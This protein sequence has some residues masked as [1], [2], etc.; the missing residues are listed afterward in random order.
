MS[1]KWLDRLVYLIFFLATAYLFS[2]M[3]T[4][5]WHSL[6]EMGG[7]G[8]KNTYT[9]IYQLIYGRGFHFDGMNYPFG[10]QI[11]Y[12][13]GQS[14]LSVP[15]SYLKHRLTLEQGLA[16]MWYAIQL[17]YF[18]AM[19]FIYKILKLY[20]VEVLVAAVFSILIIYLSPQIHRLHSHFALSYSC[21]I[22]ILIYYTILYD[23]YGKLKYLLLLFPVCILFEFIHPYFAATLLVWTAFYSIMYWLVK[24]NKPLFKA[25]HL[26]N[27]WLG[28]VF[29]FGIFK[30]V[31][32][33]TDKVTD[34][35]ITPHG[36][37]EYCVEFKNIFTSGYS[38]FWLL[39]KPFPFYEKLGFADEGTCYIGIVS[40]VVLCVL[41]TALLRKKYK[42]SWVAQDKYQEE[43]RLFLLLGIGALVLSMGLPFKLS[44][45]WLLDIFTPFKQFRS[46]G[47]F[48]WI[49]YYLL[50]IYVV[51]FIYS[52][53]KLLFEKGR[54]KLAF[55]L[56][57]SAICVWSFEAYGFVDRV[58][59]FAEMNEQHFV[60]F[61]KEDTYNWN[62]YLKSIG[63]APAEFQSAIAIPFFH[64]GSEKLWVCHSDHF[65]GTMLLATTLSMQTGLPVFDA[66]MSRSSWGQAFDQVKIE[67]GPYADKPVLRKLKSDKP[68]L[69]LYMD[70]V[71]LNPDQL[72]ILSKADSIG[73]F[74]YAY[75]YSLDPKKL[76]LN[77]DSIKNEY[78]GLAKGAD[79]CYKN[80]GT[81]AI[82]HFEDRKDAAP[83]FGIHGHTYNLKQDIKVLEMS[84]IPS[85]T[86]KLFEASIWVKVGREDYR[87]PSMQILVY[88]SANT[89]IGDYSANTKNS[90]DNFGMWLRDNLF[91]AMP[92]KAV[93]VVCIVKSSDK[94]DYIAIDEAMLRP[95]N[96][97]IASKNKQ[98]RL[99]VNNH[100]IHK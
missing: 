28:V 45:E 23:R 16:V 99:M 81:Y 35:P 42:N 46:L 41:I 33:F 89:V 63:H 12:T 34:R 36:I 15:L 75:V 47:R 38:A 68:I 40:T 37:F 60:E 62:K 51:V 64:V 6:P 17:S 58:H 85:D 87:S 30:A 76:L 44:M 74:L 96:S 56:L 57:I 22:P 7:D 31:L 84:V 19:V 78:A 13:D 50:S 94:K 18:L 79:Y 91:F 27:Y 48:G 32:F 25:K 72:Y 66:C 61:V 98:G 86:Y 49:F 53:Y 54:K 20:D 21:L 1:K 73:H 83:F 8:G 93:K 97:I 70:K 88:D 71:E 14:L 4:D 9:F 67:A 77:S 26:L 52:R 82:N 29:S 43:I 92:P 59:L 69:L 90:V 65:A 100:L 2:Y 5:P 55:S 3:F 24:K 39:F 10:E 95:A 80:E 11:I